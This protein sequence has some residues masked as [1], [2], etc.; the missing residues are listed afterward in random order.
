[1]IDKRK[2]QDA[3]NKCFEHNLIYNGIIQVFPNATYQIDGHKV[4]ELYQELDIKNEV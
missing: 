2:V 3:L 4:L 1:M